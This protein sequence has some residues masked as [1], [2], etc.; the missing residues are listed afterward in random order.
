MERDSIDRPRD[1][2]PIGHSNHAFQTK[3]GRAPFLPFR[4]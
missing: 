2:N 3:W 1:V 4:A